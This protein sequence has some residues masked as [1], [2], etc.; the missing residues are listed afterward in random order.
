MSKGGRCCVCVCVC[1]RLVWFGSVEASHCTVLCMAANTFLCY[2]SWEGRLDKGE[3]MDR[4]RY[5]RE[6]ANG[7][8]VG[9]QVRCV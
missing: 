1:C 9:E 3:Q 4:R 2:L 8:I 5:R 6:H 7:K